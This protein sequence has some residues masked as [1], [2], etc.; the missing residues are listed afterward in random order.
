M[1]LPLEFQ[2]TG[3]V[4]VSNLKF[5]VQFSHN[6]FA[7]Q[8]Q[9]GY[10]QN[11]GQ[12]AV[13][14]ITNVP[15]FLQTQH[16]LYLGDLYPVQLQIRNTLFYLDEAA[17]R[18]G[19]YNLITSPSP[20]CL[21]LTPTSVGT[22]N[23]VVYNFPIANFPMEIKSTGTPIAVFSPTQCPGSC[24][25][26]GSEV[27]PENFTCVN[28][29]CAT[30]LPINSAA[31]FGIRL[32]SSNQSLVYT[33]SIVGN[34]L[35]AHIV[36]PDQIS[37]G[38]ETSM[39]FKERWFYADYTKG[40]GQMMVGETYPLYTFVGTTKYYLTNPVNNIYQ[41]KTSVSSGDNVVAFKP[42]KA[43]NWGNFSVNPSEFVN[44]YI[45]NGTNTMIALW[46][47]SA[48]MGV[49][50]VVM[51]CSSNSQC[52]PGQACINGSCQG[53][54][55][56]AATPGAGPGGPTN[57]SKDQECPPG[58]RCEKGTC[59]TPICKNNSNCKNGQVCISG[60]CQNC[61]QNSQCSNGQVCVDGT[62]AAC[63]SNSQCS[64]GQICVSGTCTVCT[65][66]SQC[67]SG[68][69]C[70]NGACAACTNNSQCP[71]GQTCQNG[72]C[73][74]TVLVCSSSSP[75]TGGQACVN[76]TCQACASTTQCPNGQ[77]CNQ[78]KCILPECTGNANCPS[79]QICTSGICTG[80][81]A[82]SQCTSGQVCNNGLCANAS[83]P[84]W[85]NWWFW[86]IIIGA[87]LVLAFIIAWFIYSQRK[88]YLPVPPMK[89]NMTTTQIT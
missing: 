41:L 84:F 26:C 33:Y 72:V 6:N 9:L 12:I 66:N 56:V 7:N 68:Q 64:N 8:V 60:T 88:K 11:F 54:T 69:I 38:I 29:Q 32:G 62:C 42:T 4:P 52:S 59:K 47:N 39:S 65:S 53:S 57:C 55:L 50:A 75:C 35:V 61:A 23:V 19:T 48:V 20:T 25:N 43:V 67:P 71:S 76:G 44:L 30:N 16:G 18:S 81:T 58:Q 78:G 21:S 63:T 45:P 24:V 3:S 28:G 10:T 85:K 49:P 13:F 1:S 74:S 15:P 37:A 80:C 36:G 73:K 70:V 40:R 5:T 17:S 82:N 2:L 14:N 79:G 27:C 46:Q 51:G 87:F 86:L 77:V 34:S 22:N 83:K 31:A 89:T